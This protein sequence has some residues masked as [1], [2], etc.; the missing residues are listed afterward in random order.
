MG[1]QEKIIGCAGAHKGW[2]FLFTRGKKGGGF[3]SPEEKEALI[4]LEKKRR[5]LLKENEAEWHLKSRELWLKNGDDNTKLFQSYA[6]GRKFS[7]T[8][9]QLKDYSGRN[10]SSYDEFAHLG[11]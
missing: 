2:S 1:L 6:K 7:N 9:W 5:N 8:I 11:T 4:S 3:S 10:F